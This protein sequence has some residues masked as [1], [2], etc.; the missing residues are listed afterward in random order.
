MIEIKEQYVDKKF[1][2]GK[3][4]A[5]VTFSDITRE[6]VTDKL[7]GEKSESVTS[8]IPKENTVFI[9]PEKYT[10]E[11]I[12]KEMNEYLEMVKARK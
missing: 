5:E 7:T 10:D 2:V 8:D 3:I 11:E 1:S 12:Q 9:F 4:R 6:T